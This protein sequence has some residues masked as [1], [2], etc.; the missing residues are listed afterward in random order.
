MHYRLISLFSLLVI[1]ALAVCAQEVSGYVNVRDYIAKAGNPADHTEAIRAAIAESGKQRTFG[2]LFPP[3][4][5]RVS[6]TI[7]ISGVNEV[8]G[9]AYPRIEQTDP[10]KDIFYSNSAWRKTV[11][12]MSFHSGRDQVA[13]GN[14]NTDQGF[15]LV[16]DCR[17]F[18][19][20]GVAVR[21]IRDKDW[22]TASTFCLV[23]KCTFTD[24]AQTLISVSDQSHLRDCWISTKVKQDNKAAIE[25]YGVL[26]CQ[27]ILGVPRVSH[28]DQRWIDNYGTLTCKTFRFGGEGA[29]FTPVVNF[30]KYQPKLWG[31]GITLEDCYVSALGNNKRACAIYLEEIP[32]QIIIKGCCLAGV[33]AVKVN[34]NLDLKKYFTGVRPGMLNFDIAGNFGEFSGAL[35]TEMIT[36]AANRTVGA[37]DY[38]DKQLSPAATKKALAAAVATAKRI[39]A[40]PEPG[41]M[42]Y[43]LPKGQHG[44]RQ[45]TDPAGYIEITPKT[46]AWDLNDMLDGIT[47]LTS[48]YLAMA[49]V[50]DDVVLMS[51]MD[52][53]SYPHLRIRN[54]T[55]DL[56]KT[57]YLTWRLKDNG[58]K[59]GHQAMKVIN[60]ATDAMTKLMEDYNTDQ[61][62]YYAYD[63]RKALGVEHGTVTIDLKLYLCGTRITGPQSFVK[64]NKGEF[65]LIDFI[66]LEAE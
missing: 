45:V 32:N 12:G 3:G 52:E 30:A 28:N 11:R 6:D 61:F 21:F 29:G 26:T 50:G 51:R 59:G 58:V 36:A 10:E 4:Y 37:I 23:E 41:V 8:V 9:Q 27:N 24:C 16:S 15:L 42:T 64:I 17:F 54:I 44:H 7:D 56:D 46:H 20:N 49:P 2:L 66:R 33:P 5:Y 14:K 38:G 25:N 57:P 65:F 19:A 43:G 53:G 34:P 1:T 47:E 31:G 60:N 48:A 22:G 35:P 18:Q 40:A 39:P 62:G 63:L 13:L 55:V